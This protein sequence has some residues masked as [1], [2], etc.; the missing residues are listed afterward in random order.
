MEHDLFGKPVPTHRAKLD[1]HAF[2]DHARDAA[3][4]CGG[5]GKTRTCDLRFR[6]PLLYP[7]ELRDQ[8]NGACGALEVALYSIRGASGT[9]AFCDARAPEPHPT[10]SSALMLSPVLSLFPAPWRRSR[11]SIALY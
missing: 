2:P 5:P 3:E 1:G 10:F 6:K 8:F 9:S 4:K 7:A 11:A